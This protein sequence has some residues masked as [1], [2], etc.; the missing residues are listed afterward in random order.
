M[1]WVYGRIARGIGSVK[2]TSIKQQV[3]RA[4][5]YSVFV[6]GTYSFSLSESALLSQ[7][8]AS[9]QEFD[10]QQLAELKKASGDDKA[11]G[12]ALRYVAMRPRSV[13]ELETYLRRKDV[14]EPVA[15][16]IIK[17]LEA[18]DLLNDVA[19][20]RAWVANR[21]LLKSTSKRKLRLELQQKRLSAS[22]I[23]QVLQ[24]DE[25][26]ERDTLR[27]LVE[28]KRARY[29]DE[30]KFM[31]YLARQGFGYS[32]IKSVLHQEEEY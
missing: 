4:D 14:E 3:K 21:R 28:K 5:R 6:D 15:A 1:V 9:G 23:D 18:V 19:F 29:P 27:E 11:Y 31:Q 30:Q 22:V 17:R 20:G 25:T 8:L 2:I 12:N 7:G 32:D 13:W 24:E 16:T 26:D 10:E